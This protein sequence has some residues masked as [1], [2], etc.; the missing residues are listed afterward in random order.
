MKIVKLE[1]E[2][3]KRIKAVDIR[4]D[5]SLVVIGGNNAQGKT[6]VLDSIMYAL[7]GTSTMP[8]Q[9]IRNGAKKGKVV[10]DLG[11]LKVTR[12]ITDK[13]NNLVV[14]NK[15]G[16]RKG[17]PQAI[18]DELTGKLTFDPLE[19]SRMAPKLQLE[20][21]KELV[22]LDFS[23]LDAENK[24]DYDERTLINR[25]IKQLE[26]Q[27][28]GMELISEVAP[29]K[30]VSIS[31]LMTTLDERQ[32][33]NKE[34][35]IL[36][37]EI[38]EIEGKMT[39]CI[40]SMEDI[41][42]KIKELYKQAKNQEE[43]KH[44][45]NIE[46]KAKTE[47]VEKLKDADVEEI[48]NRINSAE[49]INSQVRS[50]ATRRAKESEWHNKKKAEMALTDA[51]NSNRDERADRLAEADMP[52]EG[53]GFGEDGVMYNNVPFEQCSSA[54]QLRVSVAMG[55]AM[56]PKLKV[57]L[58]RDGS[59]LDNDSLKIVADMAD[60]YDAQVWMERVGKGKEVSVIIED[61]QVEESEVNDGP[62]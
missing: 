26:G 9:P 17:S 22:G 3:I 35:E 12:T 37:Q 36:R 57:V 41:G 21:L 34:N 62:A 55:L 16:D 31:E 19:F 47:V 14:E 39:L 25:E 10:V 2:N 53:L 32:T 24:K 60:E 50:N 23:E 61:G 43:Y 54:E 46:Y 38:L 49:A 45:L 40:R 4:P 13:T 44:H 15:D 18:M 8:P 51:L 56:N 5:G 11:E 6:S 7:G 52:V 33:K 58:I 1:A 27:I 48:R 28:K 59:L 30:E 42:L 29:K 20:T